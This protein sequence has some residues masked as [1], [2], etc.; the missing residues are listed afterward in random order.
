M[1]FKA[2]PAIVAR[3]REAGHLLK[4]EDV[5]HSYPHCWRC[6]KPVLFRATEQWFVSLEHEALRRRALDA[7]QGVQWVPPWG[8][9]RITGMI[10]HRPDW[11][12]SR[13]RAWGVPVVAFYC[14][15]C[16]EAILSAEVAEHVAEVFAK[17]TS[18]AWFL[19]GP[20]ELVPPGLQCSRCGGTTFRKE[21]D[22]LVEMSR[23]LTQ[24][25]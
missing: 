2:D 17:E 4:A 24:E 15:G 20:E 9:E 7:I 25:I 12:I 19:R 23:F 3:L 13:Q 10:E 21:E 1:V 18:D 11:C 22:I 16:D 8:R 6:K 5:R 14:A